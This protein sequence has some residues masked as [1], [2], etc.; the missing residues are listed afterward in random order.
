MTSVQLK[1]TT[2]P[3][4]LLAAVPILLFLSLVMWAFASPGGSSPDDNFHLPSIWCGLGDREG[5]CEPADAG[6]DVRLVP[7]ALVDASCYAFLPEE[8]G[9]CWDSADDD[10]VPV[11]RLNTGGLYPPVFYGTMS[12][13]ASSDVEA[14]VLAMRIANSALFTGFLT[15]VFIALPRRLRFP[16]TL[17][18]LAT[19]VP[20]GLFIVPSTN[21]TSWTLL[22]AATVW[23]TFLG[24]LKTTGRRQLA[25]SALT[26]AATVIGA[27]AR[28]DAA[29][30]AVFGLLIACVLGVRRLDRSMVLPAALAI[31][32]G[33]IC[34]GFY[35]AAGQGG[36]VVSGLAADQP[37]LTPSQ[38]ADNLLNIPN[39]W[40]GALGGWGLGWLDTTM[41]A[42]VS[43][44]ASAVFFGA[45]AIGIHRLAW[46]KSVALALSVAAAWG[47][48]F[49]LLVQS[50]AVIGTQVQPRYILPLLVILI[51][52]ATLDVDPVRSWKGPRFLLAGFALTVAAGLAIHTNIRRYTTGI[53]DRA[54]DPGVRAEWW[55]SIAPPPLLV[56][57]LAVLTFGA[58]FAALHITLTRAPAVFGVDQVSSENTV[59]Q[60]SSEARAGAVAR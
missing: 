15:L 11:E 21:P 32:S 13:F 60:D 22:S 40:V 41:P 28:A 53:D 27:G 45:I 3:G 7:E 39:L 31:L 2:R 6:G 12:L 34:L 26:V 17:S 10:L 14:S 59:R 18:V 35:L 38:H 47:V 20:L 44:F 4:T 5:L 46:R 33:A 52:V 58:I 54:I 51:G 50:Q 55:W 29:A 56:V 37:P 49:V 8:S 48:P 30:F 57:V 9:A 16:L 19:I 25:L 36:A 23:I 1:R 43:V 24:V 42:T